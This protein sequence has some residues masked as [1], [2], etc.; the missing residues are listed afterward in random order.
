VAETADATGVVGEYNSLAFDPG[1]N[2]HVSYFDNVNGNLKYAKKTGGTWTSEIIESAG[3]VGQYTS[4]AIDRYGCAPVFHDGSNDDLR[5]ATRCGGGWNIEIGHRRSVGGIRHP[6]S[7]SLRDPASYYDA[8]NDALKYAHKL[9]ADLKPSTP[10]ARKP[11]SPR[12][13]M[14]RRSAHQLRSGE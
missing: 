3:Y 14:P 10:R 7:R 9:G 8:T 1:G 5:Y 4:L 13:S 11:A 12:S 6:G 2:P